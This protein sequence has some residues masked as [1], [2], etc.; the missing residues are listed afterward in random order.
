[1]IINKESINSLSTFGVDLEDGHYKLN[2]LDLSNVG[3]YA[4]FIVTDPL[5]MN[6]ESKG[7]IEVNN[8]VFEISYDYDYNFVREN[9]KTIK[10][11]IVKIDE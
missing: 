6:Y 4:R 3:G 8:H 2:M 1:M 10:N 9:W 5:G 7:R 11:I